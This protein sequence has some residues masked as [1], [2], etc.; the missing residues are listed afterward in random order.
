MQQDTEL[1]VV[2]MVY[3][4]KLKGTYSLILADATND[5]KQFSIL[6]GEA[7]AQSIALK[8]HKKRAPRP[9][10][11]DL[12]VSLLYEFNTSLEKVVI[13]NMKNDVFYSELHLRNDKNELM[14]IDSRTSDAVALATRIDVPIF[15]NAE[16]WNQ[17]ENELLKKAID[18]GNKEFEQR[19]QELD[20]NESEVE[21][22]FESMSIERL[23][24]L[25][26]VAIK[27]ENYELAAQI[28][29]EIEQKSNNK[30]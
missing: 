26:E 17:I 12:I 5:S 14:K 1:K 27:A 29:D 9:L 13:Y 6:I 3:N 19:I 25:L 23:E 30:S 2:G 8:M 4:Q 10:T 28:R 16:V 15:I 18:L 20:F 7:E 22:K 11:H 24:E 21:E